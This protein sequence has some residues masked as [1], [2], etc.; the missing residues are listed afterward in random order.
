VRAA[1]T[2]GATTKNDSRAGFS[3]YGSC[4]DLYAPGVDILSDSYVADDLLT[5][6]SGTSMAT[7]HVTGAAALYLSDHPDA[8]PAQ[9]QSALIAAATANA[10]TNVS[11]K[12][13]RR[14]LFSLP[15]ATPPTPTTTAGAITSGTALLRGSAICSPNNRYCLTQR[16][17][18][19]KLVLTKTGGQVLWTNNRTAAWTTVDSSGNFVSY[20]AYGQW[21]WST[22]TPGVGPSTLHV[23]DQG[24]LILVNDATSAVEW[25]SH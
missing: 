2:V 17:S 24:N 18:D 15:K 1:I 22:H 12:W 16:K 14:L 6:M 19:G 13:P 23:Q 20:D 5:T 3:N 21:I 4:V 9:V 8:T 11:S 7:P 25:T 10:V